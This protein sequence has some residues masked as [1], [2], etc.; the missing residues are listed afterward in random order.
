MKDL[1]EKYVSTTW[2]N[3]LYRQTYLKKTPRKCFPVVGERLLFK[4][5]F[6]LIWIMV[7]T[8]SKFALNKRTLDKKSV[9]T[10]RNEA[11]NR[12]SVFTSRK[13]C[14]NCLTQNPYTLVAMKGFI[15][16]PI[17]LPRKSCFHLQEYLQKS[18]KIVSTSKNVF[19]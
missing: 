6:T 14:Y 2:K 13:N 17:S 4:N 15:K 8:S 16:A 5:G 19:L 9:S 3:C 18:K 11:F 1:L 12:K 7:S 10:H